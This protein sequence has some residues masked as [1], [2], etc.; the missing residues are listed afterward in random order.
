[1]PGLSL[2]PCIILTGLF[3]EPT[4]NGVVRIVAPFQFTLFVDDGYRRT[5][6]I[7]SGGL[8]GIVRV[9]FGS[10]AYAASFDLHAYVP[11]VYDAYVEF[12]PVG[13]CNKTFTPELFKATICDRYIVSVILMLRMDMCDILFAHDGKA[14]AEV[15]ASRVTLLGCATKMP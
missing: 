15:V 1:M 8:I 10:I 2:T 14:A 6:T 9:I 5:I 13:F 7:S 3:D 11:S 12:V 4:G